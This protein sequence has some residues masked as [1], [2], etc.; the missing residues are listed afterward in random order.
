[1]R[2]KGHKCI[3]RQRGVV[4]DKGDIIDL[5]I[6]T[7]RRQVFNF[8]DYCINSLGYSKVGGGGGGIRKLELNSEGICFP[9]QPFLMR[10]ATV[11]SVA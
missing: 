11:R 9:S 6:Q 3:I 1:M 4:V 10:H 7:Q 2:P 8:F 5:K